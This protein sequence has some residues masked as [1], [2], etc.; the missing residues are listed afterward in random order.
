LEVVEH[1]S[2]LSSK[3]AFLEVDMSVSKMTKLCTKVGT[4]HANL[5]PPNVHRKKGRDLKKKKWDNFFNL[6]FEG[7]FNNNK[8][9][10]Y[11]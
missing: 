9:R 2:S 6:E 3:K 10:D 4:L 8:T 11:P 5:T 7:D 1:V